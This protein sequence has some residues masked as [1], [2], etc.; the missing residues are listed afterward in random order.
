MK[1]KMQKIKKLRNIS[2][3]F[4]CCILILG[5]TV[6]FAASNPLAGKD[7]KVVGEIIGETL[8]AVLQENDETDNSSKNNP[9]RVVGEFYGE[10]VT[11]KEMDYRASF[12]KVCG[13]NN[14]L[15]DAWDSFITQK[16][17]YQFAKSH[18]LIPSNEEV[19]EF[20]QNMRQQIESAPGGKEYAQ[21]TIEAMGMTPD[22][23]WNEYKVKYEAPMQ[24]TD[25]NVAIYLDENN[26]EEP[27]MEEMLAPYKGTFIEDNTLLEKFQ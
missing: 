12:Y 11:A 6:S 25:S 7:P 23:Y 2:I 8:S 1:F 26:I 13:S 27:S 10:V 24:L 9:N 15:K 18:D 20:S 5:I 14:P 19:R 17:I 22:K 16:Y 21:A 3:F 4:I